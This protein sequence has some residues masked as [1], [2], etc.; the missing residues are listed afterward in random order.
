[1]RGLRA[2]RLA[3]GWENGGTGERVDEQ[4]GELRQAACGRIRACGHV[5]CVLRTCVRR[6]RWGEPTFLSRLVAVAASQCE[7]PARAGVEE[8]IS[9]PRLKLDIRLTCVRVSQLG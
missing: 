9:P 3:G 7:A 4:R 2:G 8:E 6:E 5:G 1:M